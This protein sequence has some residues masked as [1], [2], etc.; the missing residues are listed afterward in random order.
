M[1]TPHLPLSLHCPELCRSLPCAP[2]FLFST[3]KS[4]NPS[5]TP[6]AE[7][8]VILLPL[9][10]HFPVLLY[11]WKGRTRTTQGEV[12]LT[13]R[14]VMPLTHSLPFPNPSQISFAEKFCSFGLH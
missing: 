10:A 14:T 8:W 5:H 7:P 1:L 6:H 4:L 3:P 11:S 12:G 2:V 13:Q 9:S